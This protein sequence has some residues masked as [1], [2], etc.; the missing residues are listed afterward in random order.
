MN[1]HDRLHA[2]VPEPPDLPDRAARAESLARQ[3]I[4]HQRTTMAGLAAI[5]VV[6]VVLIPQLVDRSPDHSTGRPVGSPDTTPTATVDTPTTSTDEIECV[7]AKDAHHVDPSEGTAVWLR[8][9]A[10]PGTQTQWAQVPPDALTS[11]LGFVNGWTLGFQHSCPFAL[12]Q[13][14]RIQV[15]YADGSTAQIRGRTDSCQAGTGVT[16]ATKASGSQIYADAMSA[17]G[18]AYAADFDEV[19]TPAPSRCPNSLGLPGETDIDGPSTSLDVGMAMPLTATSG[20]LC[21][22]HG[23]ARPPGHA[24]LGLEQAETLRIQM[25]AVPPGV[26]R[27]RLGPKVPSFT[28]ILQDKTG[29]R[30]TFSVDAA[31][32]GAVD[33][34]FKNGPHGI[35]NPSQILPQPTR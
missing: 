31:N 2:A 12:S 22:W 1:L 8:F 23:S 16:T 32:C 34:E 25:H 5:A 18:R 20:L 19:P 9:C 27:C 28:V 3:R 14:F 11:N 10:S 7:P 29:T 30:R 24:T 33:S 4:R 13:E 35:V 26:A 15:G 21:F 17:F 6:L